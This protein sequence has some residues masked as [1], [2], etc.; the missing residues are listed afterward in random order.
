MAT[1]IKAIGNRAIMVNGNLIYDLNQFKQI[2]K[3][4]FGRG[5]LDDIKYGIEVTPMHKTKENIS[6]GVSGASFITTYKEGEEGD[7]DLDFGEIEIAYR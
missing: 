3:H 6:D 2:R 1:K 4:K 7:C 5:A